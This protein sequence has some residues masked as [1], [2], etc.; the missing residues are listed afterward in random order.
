[1]AKDIKEK[2]GVD[3]KGENTSLG[4]GKKLLEQFLKV[5]EQDGCV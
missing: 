4:V 1:M 2:M 5:G 3:T